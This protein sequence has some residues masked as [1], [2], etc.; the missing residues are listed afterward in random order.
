MNA[1]NFRTFARALSTM[2]MMAAPSVALADS[3]AE[4]RAQMVEQQLKE[5]DIT[6]PATL[7]A[8]GVVPRHRFVPER[9]AGEAYEDT[10]LPIGDG[11]T[12]SQPYIVALMTQLLELKRGQKV[13][14]IGT[15]SG[16]QAAVLLQ[17]TSEVYTIEIVEP[18]HQR[19]KKVLTSLGMAPERIRLGDGYGGWKEAA[20]FDAIVVTAAPDHLPPALVEQL[21]PGGRMIIPVGPQGAVQQL[22][23]VTKDSSGKVS[24][25]EAMPVRF[26]PFTGESQ[27]RRP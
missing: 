20:P 15:G 3:F 13:L 25:R 19:A 27:Q 16:Y 10:P 6:D 5:R 18:L 1:L 9:L 24:I 4:A 12:I 22:Q 17:L 26:V 14:E 7:A 11:Q 8:M 21:K 23:I 2:S